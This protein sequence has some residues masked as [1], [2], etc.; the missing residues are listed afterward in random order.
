ML[1]ERWIVDQLAG[2][3]VQ[4]LVN[5]DDLEV[6]CDFGVLASAVSVSATHPTRLET[7]TKESNIC[8]S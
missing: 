2:T 1:A 4:G 7:R 5:L 3:C 8:A 6:A